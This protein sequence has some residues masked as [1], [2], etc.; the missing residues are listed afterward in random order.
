ML[1]NWATFHVFEGTLNLGIFIE[2]FLNFRSAREHG[3]VFTCTMVGNLYVW[4]YCVDVR[5]HWHV[6]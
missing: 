2:M 5:M 6:Y 1:S 4:S 3:M